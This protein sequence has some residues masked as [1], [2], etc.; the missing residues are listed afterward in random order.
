MPAP[1]HLLAEPVVAV[2][3]DAQLDTVALW[4]RD[5]RLV[6]LANHEHVFKS[7]VEAVANCILDVHNLERA[8]VLLAVSD[9]TN[10]PH[11]VSTADRDHVAWLK[12]DIVQNLARLGVRR[13]VSFTLTSGSG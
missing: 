4:Q 7:G 6:T 9:D 3:D 10:T 12:L 13:T 11:V 2:L 5:P 8:W 1:K